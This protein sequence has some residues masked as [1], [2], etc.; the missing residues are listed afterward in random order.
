VG[1]S[2]AELRELPAW[3][4]AG[5]A[6]PDRLPVAWPYP[7]TREWAWG[8]S[9]GEGVRVCILD[10]GLEVGHPLVG[11]VERAVAVVANEGGEL[12]VVEDEGDPAGH[13]TACAGIVRSLAPGC[14]ISSVLDFRARH[15]D[16]LAA[17]P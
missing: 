5:G 1:A 12:E 6:V 2:D 14:S 13:G 16:S 15:Q 9:R 3:S 4:L 17:S 8:G 10:T 11:S 7:L